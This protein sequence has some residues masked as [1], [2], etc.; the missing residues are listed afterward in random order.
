MNNETLTNNWRSNLLQFENQKYRDTVFRM[1]FNDK[2]RLLE[3]YN[4]INGT[5]Y[6]NMDDLTITTLEG[7]TYLNMKNDVSFLIDF[8]LN[9]FE[10]QSTVC[11]NIPLRD[12]YY[13]AS[14]YIELI[15]VKKTYRDSLIKIPAPKFIVFYNGMAD[16]PDKVTYKLSD[17]YEKPIKDNSLELIVAMY[18]INA[19]H[20]AQLLEACQTLKGYSIFV[21]KVRKYIKEAKDAYNLSH[22]TPLH[23]IKKEDIEKK[24]ISDAVSK[25]IDECIA[26]D[27]LKDFFLANRQEVIDMGLFGYTV[28]GHMQ[29]L[30]DESFEKGVEKGVEKGIKQGIE[31]GADTISDLYAWL[32][33]AGRN[34]DMQRA[35]TDKDFRA[36]LLTE[37]KETSPIQ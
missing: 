2:S 21:S 17:M 6:T 22:E 10:H 16:V 30:Q 4:A 1:L 13:V 33:A 14:T 18:N 37:Y 36:K 26:E 29:E 32:V 27:I 20:S 19:G 8:E 34:E 11:P 23:I 28:E 7:S 3:L 35:F 5:N 24:I 31:K 25:A 15:P 12:L 9:M